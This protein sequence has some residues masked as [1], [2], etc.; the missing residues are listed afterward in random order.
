MRTCLYARYSTDQ[1]SQNST[2]D[3]LRAGR[4]RAARGYDVMYISY[5]QEM[6]REFIDACAMWAKAYHYAASEVSEEAFDDEDKDIL[7]YVI[8]F[9]SE[10][11]TPVGMNRHR[12]PCAPTTC[13]VPHARGD[14]PQS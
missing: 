2:A 6:A 1:Q 13:R 4:E 12:M 7:V 5:S 8:N 14:E 3:Q 11:P 9:A 10:F